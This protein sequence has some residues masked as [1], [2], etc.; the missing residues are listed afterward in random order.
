[1]ICQVRGGTIRNFN[2]PLLER[3]GLT[4]SH[5]DILAFREL[6]YVV[7][8]RYLLPLLWVIIPLFLSPAPAFPFGGPLQAK[9][10]FPLF[11]PLNAPFIE[12]AAY[13]HSFSVNLSY[14]SVY[15]VRNSAAWS[16]NLDMEVAELNFRYRKDILNLLELGIDIPV[17]SFNSGFMD[18]FLS[19]YHKT[20]GFSD[21]G[22]SGRPSNTFLYEVKKNGVLVIKAEGG[23]V[24]IGDV[25]ITAKRTLLSDDPA[26][27]LIADVELPTGS[28]SK[29]FGNGSIDAGV[30][31]LVD[32]KLSEKIKAYLNLGVVFPGDFKA[33]E[34]IAL[35]NFVYG[36]LCIEADVSKNISLLG[37]V[38]AQNSP[39]PKTGISSIDRTAVL[40]TLGGRYTSGKDSFELSFTED[41]N[42]AG[43]PDFTITLAYKKRF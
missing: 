16:V 38:F 11:L 3:K 10:E 31:L 14:S 20:F 19:S 34:T 25:R 42:T 39:F 35:K 4:R 43:A 1:M 40:L 6:F 24:G 22:R 5:V 28:A 21:Y 29:G 23:R 13:D 9:N 7:M 37:Q 41:P 26:V 27:S 2:R 30:G 32:K 18:D 15:M 8:K 33:R 36:G 12:T 17:L